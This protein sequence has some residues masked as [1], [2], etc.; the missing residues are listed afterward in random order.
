MALPPAGYH[1]YS[2]EGVEPVSPAS[3]PS[4]SQDK[5]LPKHLEELDKGHLEGELRHRQPG[6]LPTRQ[7]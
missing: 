4:L 3:S 6:T 2:P 1:G 7:P 5:G